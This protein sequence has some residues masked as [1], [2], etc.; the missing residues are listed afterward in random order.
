MR[1]RSSEKAN[2][3][4]KNRSV[5]A[6]VLLIMFFLVV[7]SVLFLLLWLRGAFLPRWV[8]WHEKELPIHTYEPHALFPDPGYRGTETGE[9][10]LS[11]SGRRVKI[12]EGDCVYTSPDSWFISDAAAAD[13]TG[14]G[15]EEILLL[16]WKRGHFGG[17][18]PFWVKSDDRGFSQ[19]LYIF[20]W[21]DQSL[22]P[23]WMAS[24]MPCDVQDFEITEDGAV[25][26]ITPEGEDSIW[27][28]EHW[29]LKLEENG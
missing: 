25:R 2:P 4:K 20:T 28:W 15:I 12:Y 22:Q 17:V 6:A 27:R 8:R 3:E 19:H 18:L 9:A 23:M 16:V 1:N 29:G 26:L 5:R 21:Q 11:L 14:D 10:L 24:K 7:L 13:I